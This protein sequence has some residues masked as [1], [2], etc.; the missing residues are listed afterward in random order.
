MRPFVERL[1]LRLAPGKTS[2]VRR[3][4]LRIA[5]YVIALAISLAAF[6]G[7]YTYDITA[8]TAE[9]T[10]PLG[11]KIRQIELRHRP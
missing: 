4:N 10:A 1:T 8:A 7:A 9:A 5:Y 6:A 3:M 11:R 2:R